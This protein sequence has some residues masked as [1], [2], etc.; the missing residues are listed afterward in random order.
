VILD[1]SLIDSAIIPAK[2]HGST[3]TKG[4]NR[5][6]VKKVETKTLRLR[7]RLIA[8]HR[9]KKIEYPTTILL[10]GTS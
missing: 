4:V 1:S 8:G 9:D 10:V 6:A 3:P 5:F 2:T 7:Q